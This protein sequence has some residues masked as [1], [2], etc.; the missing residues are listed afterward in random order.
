MNS[1]IKMAVV[2]TLLVG[3][4]ATACASAWVSA[5]RIAAEQTAMRDDK[6]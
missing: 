3:L 5:M 2:T 4:I 1:Q 6:L